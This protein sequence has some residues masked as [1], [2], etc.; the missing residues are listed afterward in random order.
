MFVMG[1]LDYGWPEEYWCR[2]YDD[3]RDRYL[4]GDP[5]CIRKIQ[6]FRGLIYVSAAVSIIVWYVVAVV[7]SR[8]YR[9]TLLLGSLSYFCSSSRSS[10]GCAEILP[11][12]SVP[13]PASSSSRLA[14]SL[15]ALGR[16][17]PRESR[18]PCRPTAAATAKATLLRITGWSATAS[19]P[20]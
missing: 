14:S 20:H 9:L 4:P 13:L 2:V 10:R 1:Q 8:A 3:E 18:A 6:V 11:R 17:A 16:Q 5:E 19:K 7:S 12:S 15:R